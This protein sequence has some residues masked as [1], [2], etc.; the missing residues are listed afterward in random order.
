MILGVWVFLVSEVPLYRRVSY[1][2][3]TPVQVSVAA[4]QQAQQHPLLPTS[5]DISSPDTCRSLQAHP[6]F[7]LPQ[8]GRLIFFALKACVGGGYRPPP[9]P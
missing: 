9:L 2:R 8:S 4:Q 7:A 1:E 3:G 6:L 5:I